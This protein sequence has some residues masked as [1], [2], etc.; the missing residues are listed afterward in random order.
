LDRTIPWIASKKY[1]DNNQ[2]KLQTIIENNFF[3]LHFQNGKIFIAGHSI[4][5]AKV[6]KE[7]PHQTI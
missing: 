1:K 5:V 7:E 6:T 2:N 3:Y 4:P